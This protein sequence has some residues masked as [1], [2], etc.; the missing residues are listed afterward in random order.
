MFP[1]VTIQA[2][3]TIFNGEYFLP[4]TGLSDSDHPLIVETCKLTLDRL[5]VAV[6]FDRDT[7]TTFVEDEKELRE[8]RYG[9]LDHLV[10]FIIYKSRVSYRLYCNWFTDNVTS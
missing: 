7:I 3:G 9:W 5:G 1:T 4:S 10:N 2:A 6:L 8:G